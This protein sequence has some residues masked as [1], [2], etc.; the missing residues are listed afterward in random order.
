MANVFISH[1][2]ADAALAE[3]LATEL[4]DKGG[5]QVWLD[6]WNINIGDSIVGRINEGLAG[7]IALVLCLSSDG[8]S[9]WMDAEWM[10]TLARQLNGEKV[11]LLPARLSGGTLPPILADRKYGDLVKEWDRGIS[12]LLKALK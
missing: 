7:E 9:P 2:G 1:R 3:R 6:I 5:H 10:S 11:K 4:R 12:S 8:S